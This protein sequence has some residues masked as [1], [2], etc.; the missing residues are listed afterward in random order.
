[1]L[2]EPASSRPSR[3]Q[4]H[5]STLLSP[6]SEALLY[7]CLAPRPGP[8]T[9]INL[10]LASSFDLLLPCTPACSSSPSQSSEKYEKARFE[11]WSLV[12]GGGK[13]AWDGLRWEAGLGQV[14]K[15]H[16]ARDGLPADGLSADSSCAC[17]S[18]RVYTWVC[19]QT[20]TA[21][22]SLFPRRRPCL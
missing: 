3:S 22:P 7:T 14:L 13:L 2:R 6:L 12:T 21:H 19:M 9:W 20:G 17:A 16:R 10:S 5:P 15:A 4:P 8:R 11:R 1:M 18:P